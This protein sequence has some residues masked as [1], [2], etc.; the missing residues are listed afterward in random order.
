MGSLLSSDQERDPCVDVAAMQ[1]LENDTGICYLN[2]TLVGL[3]FSDTVRDHILNRIYNFTTLH[4]KTNKVVIPYSLREDLLD[5]WSPEAGKNLVTGPIEKMGGTMAFLDIIRYMLAHLYKLALTERTRHKDDEHYVYY[6][7]CNNK[8]E[9]LAKEFVPLIWDID[10]KKGGFAERVLLW[11]MI[12]LGITEKDIRVTRY[13]EWQ[14]S[15]KRY[16]T[17]E[18]GAFLDSLANPHHITTLSNEMVMDHMVHV[19]FKDD[20]VDDDEVAGLAM[21]EQDVLPNRVP[22]MFNEDTKEE[23]VCAIFS[24]TYNFIPVRRASL[25]RYVWNED[26]ERRSHATVACRCN[27]RW[28]LFNDNWF[29]SNMTFMMESEDAYAMDTI[30]FAKEIQ[31]IHQEKDT[32]HGLQSTDSASHSKSDYMWRCTFLSCKPPMCNPPPEK[33]VVDLGHPW[34][35][36]PIDEYLDAKFIGSVKSIIQRLQKRHDVVSTSRPSLLM[37]N[38]IDFIKRSGRNYETVKANMTSHGIDISDMYTEP[39]QRKRNRTIPDA[40]ELMKRHV[41]IKGMESR[42]RTGRQRR[43]R[44]KETSQGKK[45]STYTRTRPRDSKG[46]FLPKKI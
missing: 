39:Q 33:H 12:L 35:Y 27:G 37:H 15:H 34:W 24:E 29:P 13:V 2:A 21:F 23:I 1:L 28:Y 42:A 38:T 45:S 3:L 4:T 5:R 11:F 7:Q 10:G 46:R 43:R 14:E 44:R 17:Y 16:R 6:K 26:E 8:L 18:E 20:V 9:A 19:G 40:K 25:G 41:H 31:R 36:D 22:P 32:R 30:A